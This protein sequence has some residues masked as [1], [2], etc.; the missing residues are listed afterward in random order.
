MSGHSKWAQIKR[1]KAVTDAKR[2][3]L[4]TKLAKN[5]TVAVREG[6][7]TD[8]SFN[9]KLRMAIE[10]ARDAAMPNE[11]I[12]RAVKRGSGE[13]KEA[14]EQVA[15]EG[16]GPGGSAFIVEAV[17]DN[18]NRTTANVR[19]I[20]DKHGGRLGE[21]G[22]VG[23]MFESKG[24]ILIEN[25]AF[26]KASADKQPGNLALELIDQG[27]EDVKETENGLE[28][29]TLPLDLEKTKK[30]IEDKKIKIL[31]SELI[32]RPAQNLEVAEQDKKKVQNLIN[33]LQDDDDVVNVHS[34]VNL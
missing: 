16:Y 33:A 8:P 7:G 27:V 11:N 4:F 15:Y 26:A 34:N 20:F 22:S 21:Q 19:S 14:I 18:K 5:I 24:Q 29:Y 3:S 10:Q 30:F 2:G 17:T 31:S 13:G 1:Q 23:W 25:S 9:F 32:M 28:V 12:D 6:G